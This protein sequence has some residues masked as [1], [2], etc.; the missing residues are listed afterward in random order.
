MALSSDGTTALV[1]SWNDGDPNGENAGSAY[2]FETSGGAWRQRAKLAPEDVD[3][4]DSFGSAVALSRDGTTALVGAYLDRNSSGVYAG[5]TYV[6]EADNGSWSQRTKITPD[7]SRQVALSVGLS[8]H[9]TT[10][11]I[12]APEDAEPNGENTGSAYVYDL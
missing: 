12:G 5:S 11:V 7:R 2:V 9:A 10:A 4:G 8:N 6:F 3:S 1:G